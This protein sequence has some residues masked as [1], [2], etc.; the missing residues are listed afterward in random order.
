MRVKCPTH[1]GVPDKTCVF[2]DVV[3]IVYYPKSTQG[4]TKL[5]PEKIPYIKILRLNKSMV[6]ELRN[7]TFLIA[8]NSTLKWRVL[9]VGFPTKVTS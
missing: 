1:K 3:M 7:F 4:E 8:G 6:N 2:N 5:T 9:N